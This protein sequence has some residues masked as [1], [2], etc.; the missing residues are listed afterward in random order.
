MGSSPSPRRSK[1]LRLAV[2]PNKRVAC[3]CTPV[4]CICRKPTTI[5][6]PLTQGHIAIVD[7]VDGDL[8]ASSWRVLKAPKTHYGVRNAYGL[9]GRRT[10]QK[11]HRAIGARMGIDGEVDH[12]DRNGLNCRR[13]N[14]RA[15]TSSQNK[16]NR[17]LQSS[18]TSGFIGVSWHKRASKWKAQIRIDGRVT[19]I[20]YYVDPVEA[21]RAYDQAALDSFGEFAVLN[22][23]LLPN[24]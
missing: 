18:N 14:L 20:G 5:E 2:L 19:Y 23:P 11:L 8:I 12:R 1:S 22:F 4:T 6:I 9:D 7:E 16:A 3:C 21:A 24:C 10:T 17:G 15:A 13:E